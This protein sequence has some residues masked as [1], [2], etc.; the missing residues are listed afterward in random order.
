VHIYICVCVCVYIHICIYYF[1]L[2]KY[3]VHL[4]FIVLCLLFITSLA[5]THDFF[6]N[7]R[8][9]LQAFFF[10]VYN[11]K[12]IIFF[13]RKCVGCIPLVLNFVVPYLVQNSF[14]FIVIFCLI[15]GYLYQIY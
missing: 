13:L 9:D 5:L 7:G 6:L 2:L 1:F 15:Y 10:Q 11:F 3:I 14:S 8:P 4:L 12:A